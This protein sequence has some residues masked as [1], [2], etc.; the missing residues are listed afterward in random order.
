MMT[1]V[2]PFG[3]KNVFYGCPEGADYR[4]FV[5][6]ISKIDSFR[7]NEK[8]MNSLLHH[9]ERGPPFESR[10]GFSTVFNEFEPRR[11]RVLVLLLRNE[12]MRSFG[13]HV[14]E[15]I[16]LVVVGKRRRKTFRFAVDYDELRHFTLYIQPNKR[17]EGQGNIHVMKFTQPMLAIDLGKASF[18]GI[19]V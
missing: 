2:R 9:T 7:L 15:K 3:L 1:V 14:K 10:R 6:D 17:H 13:R 11:I 5:V 19:Y 8:A 12:Q 4:V 18:I 16:R